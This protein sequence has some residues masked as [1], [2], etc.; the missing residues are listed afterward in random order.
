MRP[1]DP[2]PSFMPVIAVKIRVSVFRDM[3]LLG[4]RVTFSIHCQD[5]L[6]KT[7]NFAGATGF[8]TAINP[9]NLHVEVNCVKYPAKKNQGCYCFIPMK[10][11][12]I[13][14]LLFRKDKV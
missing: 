13:K 8:E 12:I 5:T 11:V 7:S 2:C 4:G 6:E 10:I 14:L 9:D 3:T 1:R